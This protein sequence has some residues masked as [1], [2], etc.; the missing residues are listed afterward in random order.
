VVGPTA[1]NWTLQSGAGWQVSLDGTT[2]GSPTGPPNNVLQ[3]PNAGFP[4]A[5]AGSTGWINYTVSADVKANPVNGH[6]RVI[7]RRQNDQNF[8]AC[9]IDHAG[10]LFLGKMYA[11]SWYTFSTTPFSFSSANFYH[12]DFSVKGDQLTC[13]ATDPTN[14]TTATVTYTANYFPSGSIGATGEYGGE[15]DNFVVKA[16]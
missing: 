11:G 1:A 16:L 10:T 5:S 8:Y 12:I 14:S 6:A 4:V 15:F 2:D 7:A 3:M 13:K 9:G